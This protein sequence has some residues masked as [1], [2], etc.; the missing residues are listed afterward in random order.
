MSRSL[1]P[2][3]AKLRIENAFSATCLALGYR[4]SDELATTFITSKASV[5][6]LGKIVGT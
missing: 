6:H 3:N 1:A 4:V 5:F 2:E